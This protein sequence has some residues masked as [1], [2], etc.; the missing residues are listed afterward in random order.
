MKRSFICDWRGLW[1]L[2][3]HRGKEVFNNDGRSVA[4]GGGAVQLN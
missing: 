3:I 2:R 4:G 1:E